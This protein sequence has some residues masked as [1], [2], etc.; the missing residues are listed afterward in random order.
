[1]PASAAPEDDF[2]KLLME[3]KRKR[4]ARM[5]SKVAA[6]GPIGPDVPS[7]PVEAAPTAEANGG[8]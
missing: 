7:A 1:M 8:Y 3:H 6:T 2:E 5:A 4:A